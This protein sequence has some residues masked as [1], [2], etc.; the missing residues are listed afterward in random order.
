MEYGPT[1][2][3]LAAVNFL[4]APVITQNSL[5]VSQGGET[6]LTPATLN[7]TG[8]DLAPSEITF[9]VS[10]TQ[11]LQ[12]VSTQTG[13]PV[14]NFTLAALQTGLIEVIQDGSSIAPVT[15]SRPPGRVARAA[16]PVW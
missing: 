8:S 7:V 10:D 2:P 16:R 5:N 9:Q 13:L 12:F 3:S 6:V 11:H 15:R 4:G 1:P 14:S